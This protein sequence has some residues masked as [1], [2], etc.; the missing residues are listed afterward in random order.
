[1]YLSVVAALL[2]LPPITQKKKKNHKR[3]LCPGMLC[4]VPHFQEEGGQPLFYPVRQKQNIINVPVCVSPS[5]VANV[6]RGTPVCHFTAGMSDQK[7]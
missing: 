3:N 7:S 2:T 5:L 4:H 1:M 6:W